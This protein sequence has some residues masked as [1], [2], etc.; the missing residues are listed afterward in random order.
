MYSDAGLI[1][2]LVVSEAGSAGKAVSAVVSALRTASV[3]DQQV[4]ILCLVKITL[5]IQLLKYQ[6]NVENVC[7][8]LVLKLRVHH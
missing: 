3:T 6:K 1:G 4:R 7:S 5:M 8:D 2:A